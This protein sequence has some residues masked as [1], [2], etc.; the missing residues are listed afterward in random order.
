ML[1]AVYGDAPRAS[2]VARALRV[3]D[4]GVSHIQRTR[5]RG[6]SA[7]VTFAAVRESGPPPVATRT[8]G[9]TVREPL[10]Q[11]KALRHHIDRSAEEREMDEFM[12]VSG[13]STFSHRTW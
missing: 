11:G 2:V 4:E 10:M 7:A 13:T 8:A 12:P 9:W 5:Q 1:I 3:P 6:A